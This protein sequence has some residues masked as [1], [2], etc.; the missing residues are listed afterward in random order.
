MRSCTGQPGRMQLRTRISVGNSHLL[1]PVAFAEE[2]GPNL[3]T[4]NNHVKKLKSTKHWAGDVPALK[5]WRMNWLTVQQWSRQLTSERV[6]MCVLIST[7]VGKRVQETNRSKRVILSQSP[8]FV[9][10][11]L[12]LTAPCVRYFAQRLTV[13][14]SKWHFIA[15]LM[16]SWSVKNVNK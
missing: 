16:C 11:F 10:Y 8:Y 15:S 2:K 14:M 1:Q 7:L 12:W 3:G 6:R 5:H 4:L 9:F 13:K